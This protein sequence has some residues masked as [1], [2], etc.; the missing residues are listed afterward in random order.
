[1]NFVVH[2]Y[3]TLTCSTQQQW[4]T[5]KEFEHI[6][7]TIYVKLSKINSHSIE[8]NWNFSLFLKWN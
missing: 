7:I 6:N 4:S 2:G 1:M 3:V 8:E 5:S